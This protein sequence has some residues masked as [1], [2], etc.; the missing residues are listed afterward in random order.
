VSDIDVKLPPSVQRWSSST[1]DSLSLPGY[2]ILWLGGVFAFVAFFMST[3]AQSVVAFDITGNNRAVG[4]VIFGQGLS[5]GLLA[6]FGGALADRLSKRTLLLTTQTFVG[7]VFVALGVLILT[8]NISVLALALGSFLVGMMFSLLG[9][10]RQAYVGVLVP[11]ERR[12]NAI[13][14]T[15]VALNAGRVIGPFIAAGMLAWHIFGATGTYFA[16][17]GMYFLAVATVA[18]L[19]RT[20]A[21]AA[22]GPGVLEDIVVGFRYAANHP[23]LRALLLQFVLVWVA[24]FPF[25]AIMP[26]FVDDSLGSSTAVFGVLMGVMAIGGLVASLAVAPVA[27]SPRAPVF[28]AFGSAGFGVTLVLTGI[29]PNVLFAAVAVFLVGL[30][31]GW[32][33]TLNNAVV[34]READA[35]YYGRVMSLTMMAFALALITALPAGLLADAVGERAA[36]AVLGTI[37]FSVVVVMRLVAWDAIGQAGSGEPVEPEPTPSPGG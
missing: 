17:G 20:E 3:T 10:T 24:G 36:L 15:Q 21:R 25:I 18:F 19:P 37:V 12:G 29:S 2:R 31:S 35:E 5:M 7:I 23:R 22:G 8:D 6:P 14:M 28:M 1:F 13:A 33:Q 9:P 27:D 34:V 4:A 26:A 32:Y 16:M 11:Q 30:T